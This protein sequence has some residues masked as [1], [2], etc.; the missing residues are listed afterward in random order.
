MKS[1]RWDQIRGTRTR[2]GE[3]RPTIV[4]SSR[5]AMYCG[6]A[7]SRRSSDRRAQWHLSANR[8]TFGQRGGFPRETATSGSAKYRNSHGSLGGFSA[9][10]SWCPASA[11]R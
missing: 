4:F 5:S 6:S 10:S 3:R 11:V 9:D 2:V 7:F 1:H 8:S